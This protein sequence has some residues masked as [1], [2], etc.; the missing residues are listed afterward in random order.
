MTIHYNALCKTSYTLENSFHFG[1][2]LEVLT[3]EFIENR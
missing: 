3:P 2:G 1:F